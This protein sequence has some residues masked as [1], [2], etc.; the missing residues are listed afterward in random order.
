[1]WLLYFILWQNKQPFTT[2]HPNHMNR[3]RARQRSETRDRAETECQVLLFAFTILL[4]QEIVQVKMLSY[5]FHAV[6]PS[7]I[8]LDNGCAERIN[9]IWIAHILLPAR[10][11][12]TADHHHPDRYLPACHLMKWH[13]IALL[14]ILFVTAWPCSPTYNAL[15]HCIRP[16][17]RRRLMSAPYYYYYNSD[18]LLGT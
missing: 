4:T 3:D 15:L 10:R 5:C 18:Y 14:Q 16:V 17:D 12:T 1:M 9:L 8:R 7:L 6:S 13:G 2:P 11:E